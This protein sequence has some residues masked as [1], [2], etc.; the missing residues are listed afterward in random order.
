MPISNYYDRE[1]RVLNTQVADTNLHFLSIVLVSGITTG[2]N[3]AVSRHLFV[4]KSGVRTCVR[5]I[6]GKSWTFDLAS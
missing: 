3:T 5:T 2:T 1:S 6:H 4:L